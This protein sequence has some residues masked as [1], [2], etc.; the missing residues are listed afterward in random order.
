VGGEAKLRR[1]PTGVVPASE[2]WF[3]LNARDARWL[4]AS[5]R[6]AV[7]EFEGDAPFP[8]VGVNLSVLA[9]GQA[10]SMYHWE[11]DQEDFLVLAG[12]GLLIIEGVERS[13][14]PWD[15][16]HCPAG[17]SHVIVG[18]GQGPCIV[19]AVG[20]R[21]QSTGEN[22]GA[23]PVEPS[24]VRRRAGIEHETTDPQQAYAGLSRR[25]PVAYDPQWLPEGGT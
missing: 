22:W 9:P 19:L 15:F 25:K 18:A 3:V 21:D 17:S 5:G 1:S 24:A 2:G 12:E 14:K 16:I 7:C 11:A 8:Q 6:S 4:H 23:Y 20:A 10:M 13:L